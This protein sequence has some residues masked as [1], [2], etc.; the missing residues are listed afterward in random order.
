[1]TVSSEHL[2]AGP[3]GLP[4]ELDAALAQA[5]EQESYGTALALLRDVLPDNPPPRLLVLLAFVRFQDAREVMVT[6][7][8]PAAQEALT[9]LERAC[10]A[11]MSL[12][13][14]APLREEVERALSEET[15]RELAAERMT[16]E[17]AEQAPLE[18]VLEAASLL[19]AAHPAR[20]AE[21]FLVGARRDAS[22]RAPIHRADAGIALYQAGRV[23]E[24]QPLLEAT[25]ALDWRT[26]ELWPERLHVDWAATLLLE[27]AHRA[28]DDAAFET[29]WVQAMALG[30][31][32]QRPFPSNWLNQERMLSLLLERKDGPRAALVALRLESNRE[33]LPRALAA[34]VAE[35]RTLARQQ[36]ALPS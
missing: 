21:L 12:E 27:R 16:P 9:L 1:M 20:A 15:A 36:S 7:L 23:Q 31:Q 18:E 6:E 32:L 28:Q 29:L 2:L 19:R 4:G 25:L 14:V 33:Y 17:R 10:E 13:A 30:R 26:P 35:A 5:L 8:M 34:Q 24:A 11:G 3:W 22:G